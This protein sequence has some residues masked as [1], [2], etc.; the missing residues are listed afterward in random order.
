[1]E[2]LLLADPSEDL[3][4]EYLPKS[5]VIAAKEDDTV[6]GVLVLLRTRPKTMEIMNVS[7]QEEFQNKGIGRNLIL[8]AIEY[9]KKENCKTLEIGTGNPGVVQ[10]LLY[11]KCGFRIMGVDFDYFYPKLCDYN[12]RERNCMSRY[13]QNE[14]GYVKIR[15]EWAV[16]EMYRL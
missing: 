16:G 15:D 10:M 6:V 12:Y 9:A 13:D 7:V 11:Q 1:M 2:L 8:H 4:N 3:I 14:N 5:I